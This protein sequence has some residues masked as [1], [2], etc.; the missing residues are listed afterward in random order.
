M[1]LRTQRV[2]KFLHREIAEVLAREFT[3]Q[4]MV[5]VTGVRVTR[6]LSIAYVD[7][8]ILRDTE[9]DRQKIFDSLVNQTSAVRKSLAQRI[10]HQ[11]RAVPELR[12]FLD[13]S[14]EQVRRIDTLF[15]QIKER[16]RRE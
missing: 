1:S 4:L 15:D 9:E 5:T 8:S 10:R 11:M 12:F 14:Q 13:H 3:D 6:D 7:L 16:D 2:A